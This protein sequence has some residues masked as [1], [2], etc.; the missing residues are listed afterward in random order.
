[1]LF[2]GSSTLP[3]QS[4][5]TSDMEVDGAP[6]PVEKVP[7]GLNSTTRLRGAKS[8]LSPLLP[9]V[10]AY[11]HLLILLHL[12]DKKNNPNTIPC[13]EALMNKLVTQNRRSLDHIAAR[14]E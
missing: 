2:I 11:L 4:A 8:A 1:M 14:Y 5:S 12:L 9:E 3:F 7:S 13:A 6:A 10:D